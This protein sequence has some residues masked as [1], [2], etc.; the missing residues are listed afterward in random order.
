MGFGEDQRTKAR[1]PHGK[2][3]I[4]L[5]LQNPMTSSHS[6]VNIMGGEETNKYYLFWITISESGEVRLSN[7]FLLILHRRFAN[8]TRMFVF[9]NRIGRDWRT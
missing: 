3:G 9:S 7:R 4:E 6:I 2:K 1:K 5:H 8:N